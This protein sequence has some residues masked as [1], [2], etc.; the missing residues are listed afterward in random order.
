[1]DVGN[2]FRTY[3]D[4][5]RDY[6]VW[7][8][9]VAPELATQPYRWC[10]P[11]IG[12]AAYRGFFAERA[13]QEEGTR[14]RARGFDVS[15]LGSPAYS[16]LGWFDDPVISTFATWDTAAL[17]G[18]I[19]HELAH[20]KLFVKDDT[21]FNESFATFVEREGVRSWLADDPDQ[22][23]RMEQA[24]RANDAARDL[25]LSWRE[26]L[27]TMYR[28][29]LSDIARRHLKAEMFSAMQQC[30]ASLPDRLEAAR[31]ARMTT[32]SPSNATF[33]PIAQYFGWLPSLT[34]L[35]RQVGSDWGRF[36]EAA[37]EIADLEPTHRHTR[38]ASLAPEP[39][40]PFD[41][42]EPF[43]HRFVEARS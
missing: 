38:L 3:A 32:D 19:F 31:L 29:P 39:E 2:R 7:N 35:F 13:A 18:L 8:L 1:L 20:S 17:A 25:L 41:P 21:A 27:D 36:Y 10:Y 22:L 12:C 37:A 5:H 23:A 11:I 40:E 4:I 34:A 24:W 9:F 43:E 30:F 6:V 42:C 14:M 16:S 28:L 15:V 26:R 33:V